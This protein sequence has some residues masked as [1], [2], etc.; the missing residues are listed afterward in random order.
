MREQITVVAAHGGHLPELG[1]I[2]SN[3]GGW[4]QLSVVQYF[5]AESAVIEAWRAPNLTT[6]G[7]GSSVILARSSAGSTSTATSVRPCICS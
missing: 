4:A 1:T 2:R 6:A 5:V 7:P 3:I